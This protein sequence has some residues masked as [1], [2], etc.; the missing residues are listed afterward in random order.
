MNPLDIGF[1]YGRII[2]RPRPLLNK[3]FLAGTE[4]VVRRA[5]DG[6]NETL[7]LAKLVVLR[8]L[9]RFQPLPVPTGELPYHLHLQDVLA[10]DD[11][12]RISQANRLVLHV[13]GDTGG[14]H[15]DSFQQKVAKL[16]EYGCDRHR[17]FK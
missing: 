7:D 12:Q 13:V 4:D 5:A 2:H 15:N 8:R 17:F 16:L 9:Q 6:N 3:V 11:M 10:A 14:L 1:G